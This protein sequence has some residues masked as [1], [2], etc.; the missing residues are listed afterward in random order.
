MTQGNQV[1]I[2]D[3]VIN[4]AFIQELVLGMTITSKALAPNGKPV[5]KIDFQ[6][7]LMERNSGGN[8][9]RREETANYDRYWDEQTGVLVIEIGQ[10]S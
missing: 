7:G 9:M 3:A 4:K 8:G 2:N 5:L 10:L 1:F 6:T